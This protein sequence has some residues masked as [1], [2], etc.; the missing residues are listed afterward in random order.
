[1]KTYFKDKSDIIIERL[2]HTN[3]KY[4][5]HLIQDEISTFIESISIEND[6]IEFL[7]ILKLTI[8]DKNNIHKKKCE[9][10]N[11][12]LQYKYETALFFINQ[13]LDKMDKEKKKYISTY[14]ENFNVMGNGQ[15]FNIGNVSKNINNNAKTLE[16]Q[17]KDKIS[18][19]LKK[20][21][22]AIKNDVTIDG[23]EK[24]LILENL[25]LLSNEAVKDKDKRLSKNV[26]K[27]IFSGLNTLSSIS[28]IAGVDFKQLVEYF[29]N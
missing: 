6:K 1:M 10:E 27:N 16:S 21:T 22:E 8:E 24:Q 23:D 2:E 18:I 5:L 9:H 7:N 3:N 12:F 29:L 13:E 19:T 20:L 25:E 28:T 17:G 11:C 15:I 14:I 4:R 26:F